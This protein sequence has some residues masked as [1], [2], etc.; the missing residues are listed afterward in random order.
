MEIINPSERF[1]ISFLK[2]AAD[3]Q[4]QGHWYD[5]NPEQLD[6]YF[7]K[8]LTRMENAK[9][10]ILTQPTEVPFTE[11]WMIDGD[12]V[13]G[14]IKI[15]HKLSDSMKIRGGHI[16]YGVASYFRGRGYATQALKLALFAAKKMEIIE[17]LVTCDDDNLGSIK[18]IERNGGKLQDKILAPDRTILTRR[19]TFKL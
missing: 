2:M 10:G 5:E 14:R 7:D 13:V 16:G 12:D 18:V 6:K 8:Y 4:N 11:L 9:K 1:K 17:V 3:L 15:N 19:Y